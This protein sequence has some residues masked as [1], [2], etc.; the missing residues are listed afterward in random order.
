[1]GLPGSVPN[2][3]AYLEFV[4]GRFI[5][6]LGASDKDLKVNLPLANPFQYFFEGFHAFFGVLVQVIHLVRAGL[7]SLGN[8]AALDEF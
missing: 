4:T 8:V 6:Q 5:V 3:V 1:M 2:V 7:C